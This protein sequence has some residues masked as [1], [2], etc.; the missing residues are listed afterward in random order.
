MSLAECLLLLYVVSRVVASVIMVYDRYQ[1]VVSRVL[2][3]VITVYVRWQGVFSRVFAT[4]I[5]Y[6]L[7]INV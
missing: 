2:D 7:S 5:C 1:G 4:V 3:S 6:M